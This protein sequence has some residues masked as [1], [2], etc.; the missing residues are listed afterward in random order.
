M[1][2][3]VLED[4][5]N[6][7]F[8]GG[9]KVTLDVI[10]ALRECCD[11]EVF[12]TDPNSEFSSRIRAAGL[13]PHKMP[14]LKLSSV[15]RLL[16]P[17]IFPLLLLYSS[18]LVWRFVKTDI[19]HSRCI[20][21][22]ASK[23]G[24]VV[25][26]L[27]RVLFGIDF[28]YHAH[29]IERI[30]IIFLVRFFS[31][32]AVATICVSELVKDQLPKENATVIY[33]SISSPILHSRKGLEGKQDICVAMIGSLKAEKGVAV[34][35]DSFKYLD[36]SRISYHLF[37]AG[38]LCGYLQDKN[39]V[40]YR[41]FTGDINSAFKSQIDILVVPSLIPESFSLVS[42]EAF[43]AG[44]PVIATD[45]GMQSKHVINSGAGIL[46]PVSD[47]PSLAKAVNQLA[48]DGELYSSLSEAAVHYAASFEGDKF[49]EKLYDLI[50]C[51]R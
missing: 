18:F 15:W 23:R 34:F 21:Y 16:T 48:S 33:N 5:L 37:G 27:C 47:A 44:I 31:G 43:S 6:V 26:F 39:K 28:I 14:S 7:G 30:P 9:Q 49:K 4:S 38:I 46:V 13:V 32:F 25:S 10:A 19:S 42:L 51:V 40:I 24:L 41:G 3:V 20:V 35:V 22:A 29:M 36:N 17:L 8:G 1:R 2:I 12:D 11:F 45:I 50:D